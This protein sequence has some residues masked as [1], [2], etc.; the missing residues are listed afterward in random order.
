M[1]RWSDAL[2]EALVAGSIASL[3]SAAALA[4]AG[5][6]ECRSAAAPVNAP[7]Q[8]L[9]GARALRADQ[10]DRKHT[11]AGYLIHHFA[12]TLWAA[13]HAAVLADRRGMERPGPALAAAA[14]TSAVAAL[15]DL[16]L[17]PERFTPG[18]QHRLSTA[19]LVA[20]YGCFALGL[21]AGSL[22]VRRARGR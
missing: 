15:V 12:A 11:A 4:V 13:L 5:R 2:Q 1:R 3:L 14:V 16:R 6:R 18:F 8:W 22:A 9:W 7:S 20:T 17:T 19:A 21:A 10:A